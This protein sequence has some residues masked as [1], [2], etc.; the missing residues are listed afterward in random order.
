ME[1][2]ISR[3]SRVESQESEDRRLKTEDE[4]L[5]E[6]EFFWREKGGVK[7]LVSRVLEENG[8]ANGF[9]TRLGGVSDF[10][11]NDLNL[12]GFDEDAHENIFENRRRFLNVFDKDFQLA[13]AWQVHGD[14]VKIVHSDEDV[15]NSEEKFDALV[16]DL[17]NVLVGV[18]TADCVPVLIGDKKTKTFAAVHAGW[19]GTVQNCQRFRHQ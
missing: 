19:R 1:I 5:A 11:K 13:T 10:P 3:E 2:I 4:I 18:K 9:S 12:A 17:E 14:G 6:N 16:S 7:I 15:K 8:F